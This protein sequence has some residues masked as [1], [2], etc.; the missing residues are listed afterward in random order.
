MK[1]SRYLLGRVFIN[2]VH[3]HWYGDGTGIH[4]H[5]AGLFDVLDKI[6]GPLVEGAYAAGEIGIGFEPLVV[7]GKS[8]IHSGADF[9]L[10]GL[11]LTEAE[12][13]E[14]QKSVLFH[15]LKI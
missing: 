3:H 9:W 4:A 11:A 12:G 10:P 5:G 1:I 13:Q 15:G 2:D 7:P 14:Q 6:V 8:R